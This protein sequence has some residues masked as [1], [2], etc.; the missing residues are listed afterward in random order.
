MY[1]SINKGT[2]IIIGTMVI[3]AAVGVVI[4]WIYYGNINKSVDPR[5]RQAQVL[6]GRY[7]I[8]TSN[9]DHEGILA[10]LDSIENIYTS[11]SHYRNSYEM[12]VVENNRAS[13]FL[14]K[15]L[16]DKVREE[17]R[18]HYFAL[19][20]QH[21]L[22]SI[23]YYTDWMDSHG[24]QSEEE[25]KA[26]IEK[27]FKAD[28]ILY[29]NEKLDAIIRTRVKEIMS[30]QIET[31]RRLSVSYTNLGIIRRHE[32][33]LEKAYDYYNKALELWDEN[34]A[35]RNNMNI[36]FG[37]PP[38]KQSVLRKLFPPERK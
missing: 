14:T 22:M 37:K 17:I 21:L 28:R 9:N 23:E 6:Y 18:Q 26:F 25:L 5:V 19:A 29:Y 2:R 31:P 34:H 38:E 7:N 16:S 4:A 24:N 27:E 12:G 33:N 1:I 35:A 30:A 11:V 10:L 36:L 13:V 8:Y 15:A 3:L 20:E 32:N